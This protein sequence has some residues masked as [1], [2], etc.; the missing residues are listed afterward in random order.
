MAFDPWLG[1]FNPTDQ[2]KKEYI[3]RLKEALTTQSPYKIEGGSYT[4]DGTSNRAIALTNVDITPRLIIVVDMGNVSRINM[5]IGLQD[6]L[7]SCMVLRTGTTRVT[8]TNAIVAATQGSFTVNS[9]SY[10][11]NSGDLHYYL[12]LGS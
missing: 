7:P 2:Q 11:N 3:R 6:T 1:N 5:I 12:V 4:G 9:T 10:T 8:D